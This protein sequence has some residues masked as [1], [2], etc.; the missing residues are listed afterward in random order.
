M[1]KCEKILI[2][3]FSGSGK[4]T[5]LRELENTNPDQDWVYDDLDQVIMKNHKATELAHLIETHGWEK[6]RMWERQAL[7]GWLKDEGKGVLALGGG[8]LSQM[9][10]DLFKPS[11]KLG[12]VYLHA[13]FEDC[14]ERLNTEG[15]EPR[16]LVKLGKGELH[17]IY[18]ERHKVFS[19]I[20]WRVEN[21]K[22]TDLHQLAADFWKQFSLS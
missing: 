19:Q 13:S 15:T 10:Y 5:F 18:E 3:G 2:C 17:R 7:E 21:K 11:R 16:P 14:W 8:T 1:A 22:G 9:V 20:P 4:S 12:F 6:F